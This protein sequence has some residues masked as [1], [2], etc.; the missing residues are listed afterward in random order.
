M[1]QQG[2]EGIVQYN[3]NATYHLDSRP[4]NVIVKVKAYQ[5]AT[6]QISS[7]R[8]SEFGW[9]LQMD[10]K[11]VGVIEF[12]P[13]KEFIQAFRSISRQ[14]VIGENKDWIF[15]EPV[16]SCRVKFQCYSKDGKLRS[17]KFENFCS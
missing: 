4:Q 1:Q 7:I 12:P 16:L 3:G 2:L 6:C 8:K 17:P 11:Y 9:G 14:I 15:L 5:Y 13:P 10:G